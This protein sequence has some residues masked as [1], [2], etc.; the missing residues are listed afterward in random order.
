[1]LSHFT[2]STASGR[3]KPSA[4]FL[5]FYCCST[6]TAGSLGRSLSTRRHSG[7]LGKQTLSYHNLH[8]FHHRRTLIFPAHKSKKLGCF[9]T[10]KYPI[11]QEWNIKNHQTMILRLSLQ[12]FLKRQSSSPAQN[13]WISDGQWGTGDMAIKYRFQHP[14]G[15]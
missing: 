2:S 5:G 9:V 13:G 4:K 10:W 7:C 12:T 6:Q 8:D 1:M 3:S 14:C 11:F 15:N